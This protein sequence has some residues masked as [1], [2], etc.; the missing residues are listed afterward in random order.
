[1]GSRRRRRVSG[2]CLLILRRRRCWLFVSDLDERSD[3]AL[4]LIRRLRV[5]RNRQAGFA[6]EGQARCGAVAEGDSSAP[7][8]GFQAIAE[9]GG[10]LRGDCM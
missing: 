2:R 8:P 5:L 9:C 1:M 4:N 10:F 6:S 7:W 3:A